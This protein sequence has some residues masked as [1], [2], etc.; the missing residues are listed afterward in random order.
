M[1]SPSTATTAKTRTSSFAAL[2]KSSQRPIFSPGRPVAF[3]TTEV[4]AVWWPWPL[5][6]VIVLVCQRVATLLRAI[7]AWVLLPAIASWTGSKLNG[8]L[9]EVMLRLDRCLGR[10]KNKGTWLQAGNG[11]RQ[12]WIG[13]CRSWTSCTWTI[14]VMVRASFSTF[15][16]ACNFKISLL[17]RSS[18]FKH[19]PSCLS[20]HEHYRSTMGTRNHRN[21]F[22][23]RLF[24]TPIL[25]PLFSSNRLQGPLSSTDLASIRAITHRPE[26]LPTPPFPHLCTLEAATSPR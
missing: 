2:W 10:F 9:L 13:V 19:V 17:L 12:S 21:S 23:C 5:E 14:G 18:V 4:M 25:A 1:I 22:M 20:S 11:R 15:V 16:L 8:V 6:K 26:L 24:K 3:A 7:A